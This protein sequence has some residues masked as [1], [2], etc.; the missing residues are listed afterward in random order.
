MTEELDSYYEAKSR[1]LFFFF[2]FFLRV[3]I[4]LFSRRKCKS[5]FLLVYHLLWLRLFPWS[6]ISIS[7]QNNLF[8]M[9]KFPVRRFSCHMNKCMIFVPMF[10]RES[11]KK[12]C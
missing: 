6:Y 4:V 1:E 12:C 5:S 11:F 3:H 9:N 10:Y 7:F 8:G 2:L